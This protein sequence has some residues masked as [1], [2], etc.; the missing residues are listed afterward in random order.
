MMKASEIERLIALDGKC[1]YNEANKAEFSRLSMKLLRELAKELG[2]GK[3]QCDIRYNAAGIACS[4]DATLHGDTLY[5]NINA[6]SGMGILGRTCKGRKDYT[7]GTNQWFRLDAD[8]GFEVLL[9]WAKGIKAAG[10]IMARERDAAMRLSKG[11]PPETT[12]ALGAMFAG[13]RKALGL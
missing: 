4:G 6:D 3:G 8:A 13:E 7:G 9:A 12:A 5:I 11:L 2:F 1:G 10:D